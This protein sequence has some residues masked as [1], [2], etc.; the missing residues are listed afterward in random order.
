M[1]E[2]ANSL[3]KV[4]EEPP[5]Q[6]SLILLTENPQEL[7][8][9]IRSRAVLSARS[10]S[11][12]GIGSTAGR[13]ASGAETPGARSCGAAGRGRCWPSTGVRSGSYLAS[14]QDALVVLRTALREPDYSQLV[15]CD[16]EL[17]C[18]RGRTGKDARPAARAGQP[19]GGFASDGR[20]NPNLIR[21]VDMGPELERMSQGLTV[22]W[23]ESTS[24]ALVQVEQGMRRN[25]LRSLSLDAMAV[26]LGAKRKGPRLVILR[27]PQ[28]V[29]HLNKQPCPELGHLCE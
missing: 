23:I 27:A 13:A 4:L 22:D 12:H 17:P 25:L 15:P 10:A 18:R 21:N 6:T 14:R 2:A 3:L 26:S 7:L 16:G 19:P 8:P 9:T 5:A 29:E 24:R 20:G 11:G 28:E 1:K